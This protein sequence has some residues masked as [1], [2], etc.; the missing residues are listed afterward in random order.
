MTERDLLAIDGRGARGKVVDGPAEARRQ[1]AGEEAGQHRAATAETR[2]QAPPRLA[3]QAR[4]TR[5]P[6]EPGKRERPEITQA[7]PQE[8]V[9]R[10]GNEDPEREDES[11]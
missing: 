9:I 5:E 1:R 8:R 7:I 3:E 10:A 11:Q 6:D 4:K 2:R